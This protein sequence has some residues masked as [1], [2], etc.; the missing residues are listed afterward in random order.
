MTA[1]NFT[2][3]LLTY[4]FVFTATFLHV[5][6]PGTQLVNCCSGL[7]NNVARQN[8]IIKDLVG[9]VKTSSTIIVKPIQLFPEGPRC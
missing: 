3:P 9:K 2:C 6:H 8:E 7:K 1:D 4:V 5:L